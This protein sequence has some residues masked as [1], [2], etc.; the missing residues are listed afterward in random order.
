LIGEEVEERSKL[1]GMRE[2]VEVEIGLETEH[3]WGLSAY[4]CS[5][6]SGR[7]LLASVYIERADA[8]RK[9]QAW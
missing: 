9:S 6:I 7:M 3:P 4:L 8:M 1:R 2:A 5:M